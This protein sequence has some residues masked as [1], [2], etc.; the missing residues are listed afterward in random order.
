MFTEAEDE[1]MPRNI[2]PGSY[3]EPPQG[4]EI[5]VVRRSRW[6]TCQQCGRRVRVSR[7]SR[8]VRHNEAKSALQVASL[9]G[10]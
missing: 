6:T 10:G 7:L 5:I 4:A 1:V 8:L 9:A 2:C 3:A